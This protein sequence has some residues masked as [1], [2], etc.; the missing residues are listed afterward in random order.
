MSNINNSQKAQLL[1][2]KAFDYLEVSK[3][4]VETSMSNSVKTTSG[5]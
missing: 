3:Q 4:P 5:L 2:G 1:R